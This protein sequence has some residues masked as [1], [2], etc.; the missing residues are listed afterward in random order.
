M[1]FSIKVLLFGLFAFVLGGA[2]QHANADGRTTVIGMGIA[3]VGG[4]IMGM[5]SNSEAASKPAEPKAEPGRQPPTPSQQ[6]PPA[7][8]TPPT[9]KIEGELY[10]LSG[11]GWKTDSRYCISYFGRLCFP[12][13]LKGDTCWVRS[14]E[15]VINLSQ[16][17]VN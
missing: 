9:E 1:K 2:D 6:R 8:T 17:T 10:E 13:D 12:C 7:R 5:H 4:I 15:N 11:S 3:F 16:V 14:G